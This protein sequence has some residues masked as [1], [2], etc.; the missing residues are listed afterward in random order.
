M[1]KLAAKISGTKKETGERAQREVKREKKEVAPLAG[2]IR[3][4]ILQTVIYSVLSI[5]VVS[6]LF[7][8][9]LVMCRH[10]FGHW[11]GNAVCGVLVL[12]LLA[13]LLRPIVMKNN[14]SVEARQV[15]SQYAWGN[16]FIHFTILIRF[17]FAVNVV[18]YVIDFL[19]PYR[20]Y[21]H[22][23]LAVG[24]V[25]LIIR[26]QWIRRVS[27]KMESVFMENLMRRENASG[28]AYARQLRGSDLHIARL[29]LPEG[30]TWGGKTLAQLRIGGRN[31]VH[32]AAIV[33]DHHRINVPGG[34]SML[35][36]HDVLEVVGDDQSIEQFSQ[37]M[38][39]EV[40]S[41]IP[42]DVSMMKLV[43]IEVGSGTSFEGVL[44]KD[45]GIRGEYHCMVVGVEDRKGNMRVA[46]ADYCI[47]GG[48]KLWLAGSYE[49]LARLKKALVQ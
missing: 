26:S 47:S 10:L 9:L 35:F 14:T 23:L 40:H 30:S 4:V 34:N 17:L 11:A 37:R 22:I 31:G 48:D 12:L 43:C 13:P 3:K 7:V 18:Y 41:L 44:I 20:W 45:S 19:S 38:S 49:E 16:R 32:V 24:I 6:L 15:R 46:G 1:I 8:S 25:L 36:P 28:P 2:F 39:T 27:M 21:W 42:D 5:A 33:R 29:S